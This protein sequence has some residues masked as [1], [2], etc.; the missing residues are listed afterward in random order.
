MRAKKERFS[1]TAHGF[2]SEIQCVSTQKIEQNQLAT[3]T[4]KQSH[5]SSCIIYGR[6]CNAAAVFA[7]DM[8]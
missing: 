4:T 7:A 2:P 3:T 5:Q 1:A 8:L 6:E